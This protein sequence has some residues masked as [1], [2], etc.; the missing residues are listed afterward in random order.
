MESIG[1]LDPDS[2]GAAWDAYEEL[3]PTAQVVVRE[4]AR[5]MEFDG[6]E[7]DRRVD[8]DVVATA[9]DAIFASLLSVRVGTDEEFAA[10]REDF[11]GPVDVEGSEH[12]DHVVWHAFDGEAAAATFQEE[13]EAAVATL[14]RQAFGKLYKPL[15]YG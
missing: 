8:G 7:Y 10:W 5:A 14:R 15:F 1:R 11:D 3:G 13:R 2:P 4:V 9:R 12:V 6:E